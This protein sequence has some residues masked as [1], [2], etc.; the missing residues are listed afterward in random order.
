MKEKELLVSTSLLPVLADYLEECPFKG[1][2]KRE[3]NGVINFIR[4]LDRLL[5]EGATS[6]EMQQQMDIQQAFRQ[7]VDQNIEDI[8]LTIKNGNVSISFKKTEDND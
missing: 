7:W 5:L 6:E 1:A 8:V 2:I 3:A 4:N